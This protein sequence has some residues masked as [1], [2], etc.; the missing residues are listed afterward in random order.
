MVTTHVA[1]PR[2]A[3]RTPAGTSQGWGRGFGGHLR[4]R[5]RDKETESE[6][7]IG[8]ARRGEDVCRD[9]ALSQEHCYRQGR[10]K[11]GG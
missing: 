11:D 9:T 3:A 10:Y 5:A 2:R 7:E 6:R 8:S 4:E 1:G